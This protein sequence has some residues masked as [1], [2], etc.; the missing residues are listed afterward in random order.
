M[1]LSPAVRNGLN[2]TL[3]PLAVFAGVNLV[4]KICRV[5]L[6]PIAVTAAA[7]MPALQVLAVLSQH[8]LQKIGRNAGVICINMGQS[9]IMTIQYLALRRCGFLDHRATIGLI[10]ATAVTGVVRSALFLF[11][12]PSTPH[13]I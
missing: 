2:H 13:R 3:P 4:G 10:V 8:C 11:N 12:S 7:V 5:N 9:L 1:S 6:M